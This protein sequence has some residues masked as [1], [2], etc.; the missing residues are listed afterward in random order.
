L[1]L[2][3]QALAARR[4]DDP[5]WAVAVDD[6]HRPE[7]LDRGWIM[8]K[9]PEISADALRRALARGAFYASTGVAADFGADGEGIHARCLAPPEAR[10][11]FLDARGRVRAEHAGAQARYA[12]RGDEGFVRV[13]IAAASGERAW[14]QPFRIP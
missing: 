8:A 2:W 10:L 1:A 3:Q 9:V 12:V 14:S 13:E 11:R 5:L 7:Q 4:A 6:C